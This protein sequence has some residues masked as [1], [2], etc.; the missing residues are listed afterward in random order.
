MVI[1]E[2]DAARGESAAHLGCHESIDIL[3]SDVAVLFSGVSARTAP[4]K[5][6]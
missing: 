4:A 2:I 5:A 3:R 1:A 6:A